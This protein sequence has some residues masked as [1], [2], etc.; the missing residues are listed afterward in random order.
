MQIN[1][2]MAFNQSSHFSADASGWIPYAGQLCGV[3]KGMYPDQGVI[4]EHAPISAAKT[5]FHAIVRGPGSFNRETLELSM[6][7]AVHRRSSTK[8]ERK[9]VVNGRRP[10]PYLRPKVYSYPS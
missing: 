2:I 7:F 4:A 6:C 1:G 8:L 10:G 3:E 9:E 5:E